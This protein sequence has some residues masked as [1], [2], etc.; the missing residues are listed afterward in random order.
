MKTSKHIRIRQQQ[1]CFDWSE[2][3]TVLEYATPKPTRDG[4]TSYS[5]DH[6]SWKQYRRDT[7]RDGSRHCRLR[8]LVVVT[9]GETLTTAFWRTRRH[10]RDG[11]RWRRW[12]RQ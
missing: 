2:I 7:G 8:K 1:R 9:A 3:E 10:R 6:R 11:K 5:F 12:P 4:G